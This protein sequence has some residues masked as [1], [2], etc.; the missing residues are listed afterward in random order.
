MD[1]LLTVRCGALKPK[2][3]RNFPVIPKL[4]GNTANEC[5]SGC[6]Q[7]DGQ[8]LK[9]IGFAQHAAPKAITDGKNKNFSVSKGRGG[10]PAKLVVETQLL[11]CREVLQ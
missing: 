10:H 6:A 4:M 11:M 8:V 9:L 7:Y 1:K 5:E 2:V 3:S